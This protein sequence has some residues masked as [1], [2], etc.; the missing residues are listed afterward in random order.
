MKNIVLV[1]MPGCGKSTVGVVLAKTLGMDF[2]DTDL[3]ICKKE[4]ATLQKII[5][6]KGLDYFAEIEKGVGMGLELTDTVIATGGSM[7]LYREAMEHLKET[8]I[9]VFIDVKLSELQRRITN[10]TTRGI[11]FEKGETLSDIYLS[12]RPHY[13]EYANITVTVEDGSIEQ[14][15]ERLTETL[16]GYLSDQQNSNIKIPAVHF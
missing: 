14:T 3:I 9:V 7:V 6:K 13:E 5:E 15:V 12:R 16:R 8:G 1:G 2:I 10:I 4:G 11:T